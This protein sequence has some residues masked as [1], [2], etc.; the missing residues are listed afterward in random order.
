MRAIVYR[1]YGS[2]DVLRCEEVDKPT[3]GDDEVLVRVRAAAANPMDYGLMG[4]T[5]IMRPVT[6]LRKPK[7]TRPGVDLAGEVEA[8]GGNVTAFRPGDEVFGVGRGA[9]AEYACTPADRL[10][11]KPAR[12]TFEQAAA[13]PVAGLTA[14]QGLRDKGRIQAGQRVLINGASGGVGTFAV[15]IAK[16]LGGEVTAVCST[17]NVDLVR[18][19][20]AN[21][22]IDYT[23]EEFTRGTERY[24][25]IVDCVGNQPLSAHRRIMTAKG[26]LVAVGARA[27]GRW[28]GPLPYLIKLLVAS[29]FVSQK[30]VF[31]V[32]RANAAELTGLI[33]LVE[34]DKVRPVI[35]RCYPLGE[36][37]DA[38]RYVKEGHPRGKVVITMV[39]P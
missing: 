20:G 9:F 6:G 19:L 11:L 1:E 39:R 27:G 32:A 23:R 37:A 12:L 35:D 38:I 14:L 31:F 29:R 3:P 26:T 24:D 33:A 21:R 15:Q 16:A 36:T 28:I 13:L 5:Y 10:A 17:R 7:R 2:P 4:G 34:A 18:S 8:V 22:V 30:V 25:L